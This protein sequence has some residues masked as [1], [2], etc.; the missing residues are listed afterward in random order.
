MML[1]AKEAPKNKADISNSWSS[2]PP[3]WIKKWISVYLEHTYYLFFAESTF[4]ENNISIDLSGKYCS[5]QGFL[6]IQHLR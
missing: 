4:I 5:V 3:S 1:F 6:I 2:G